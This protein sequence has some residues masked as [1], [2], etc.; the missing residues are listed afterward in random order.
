MVMRRGEHGAGCV[1]LH[2]RPTGDARASTYAGGGS[3][4]VWRLAGR[5]NPP[6]GETRSVAVVGMPAYQPIFFA[7]E[8]LVAGV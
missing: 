6:T 5:L 1:S 3:S 8:P 4:F 2:A 7:Q